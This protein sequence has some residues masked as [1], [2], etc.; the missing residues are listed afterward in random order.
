MAKLAYKA[1][2]PNNLLYLMFDVYQPATRT[3][4]EADNIKLNS[5]ALEALREA[6]RKHIDDFMKSDDAS[7]AVEMLLSNHL[8]TCFQNTVDPT[9]YHEL[10]KLRF[11]E[12]QTLRECSR[13]LNISSERVRQL[14]NKALCM[15]KSPE[16]MSCMIDL[17]WPIAHDNRIQAAMNA[18]YVPFLTPSWLTVF[19]E[20]I[21][22]DRYPQS[23]EYVNALYHEGFSYVFKTMNLTKQQITTTIN[24]LK[25]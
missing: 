6:N 16:F 10:I 8:K 21:Q 25:G 24:L 15:I 14:Q 19:N 7:T 20:A 11:I 12:T 18:G 9:R 23:E 22:S 17:V 4:V 1:P 2:F 5:S 13:I 3:I